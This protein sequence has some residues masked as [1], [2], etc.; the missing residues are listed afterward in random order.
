MSS[1]VQESAPATPE[2]ETPEQTDYREYSRI[3]PLDTLRE[4]ISEY[5]RR[6]AL[7]RLFLNPRDADAHAR[8][9][10]LLF[11]AGQSHAAHAHLTA[12]HSP[13]ADASPA[14]PS[15]SGPHRPRRPPC[16]QPR[17]Y[18]LKGEIL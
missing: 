2:A 14:A 5:D 16:E 9:S 17:K 4:A 7:S 3:I 10:I 11:E 8:L 15:R 6:K 13:D 18:V 1:E 12:A